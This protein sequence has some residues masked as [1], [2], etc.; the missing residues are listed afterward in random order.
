MDIGYGRLALREGHFL[1]AG[2]ARS[3]SSREQRGA[4][5]IFVERTSVAGPYRRHDAAISRCH[6]GDTLVPR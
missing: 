1:K 5:R 2:Q 6:E 3:R 4:V